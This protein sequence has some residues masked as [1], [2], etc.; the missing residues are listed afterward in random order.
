MRRTGTVIVG[1]GQ[2]GLALSRHLTAAGHEHVLLD[3]RDVGDRWRSER[4]ESL[5]LL[6]P[7]WLNQLPGSAPHADPDGFLTAGEF[8][9]HLRGYARSFGAPVVAGAEVTAVERHGGRFRVA[10]ERDEWHAPNVVLA[11][12]CEHPALPSAAATLP[13]GVHALHSSEYRSPGDLPPGAV[14]VVG[15][16]PSGQ[17]IAR[18]L[19]RSGRHVVLA[20]GRHARGVR[21]YRGRDLFHWLHAVGRLHQTVEEMRD[22]EAA[23]RSPSL[24]VSGAHGGEELDLGTLAREGVVVT[25]RLEGFARGRAG[26]AGDLP[27]NVAWA[28]VRLRRLLEGIDRHAAAGARPRGPLA[29]AAAAPAERIAPVKL[30]PAPASLDLG[31]HG[32]G[33]VLWATGFHRR[34]PWLHVPATG[35]RGELRHRRGVTP[36]PGLYALGLRFQHRRSSHQIAGVGLDA[37]YLAARIA[38]AGAPRALLAA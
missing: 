11:S 7:N 25:G 8:A 2:A 28:D 17:Q 32:I 3:R 35:P 18:E 29:A 19:R 27:A 36:V 9:A 30:P 31:A 20:A 1:A 34:H 15:A 38:G 16:G 26:F 24:P 5:T 13:P 12:G 14:L 37:E 10:T 22:P 23:R 33:T 21:R 6:T 4:W